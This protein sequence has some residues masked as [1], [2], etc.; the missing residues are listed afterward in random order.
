MDPCSFCLSQLASSHLCNLSCIRK[1]D[2]PADGDIYRM[3]QSVKTPI[4]LILAQSAQALSRRSFSTTSNSTNSATARR[5]KL[6]GRPC[7]ITSDRSS[8]LS[9]KTSIYLMATYEDTPIEEMPEIFRHFSI[10]VY[11]NTSEQLVH[12]HTAPDWTGKE[13]SALYRG[14][15]TSASK[16]IVKDTHTIGWAET[17]LN[18]LSAWGL[19]RRG[20][21]HYGSAYSTGTQRSQSS[22]STDASIS[23][24]D[25]TKLGSMPHR[26]YAS[27]LGVSR[28]LASASYRDIDGSSIRSSQAPNLPPIS[29][30]PG[31]LAP[32]VLPSSP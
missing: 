10:A 32:R 3:E 15:R 29:E 5:T 25:G 23:S 18:I 30:I 31:N 17:R 11:P 22:F 21:C 16:A 14:G 20:P 6:K 2:L 13:T 4:E 27:S 24:M 1:H 12:L 8:Q 28:K 19:V 9:Q 7:I 26:G